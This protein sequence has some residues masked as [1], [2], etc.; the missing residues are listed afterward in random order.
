MYLNVQC[1]FS[2][3]PCIFV[4][5]FCVLCVL[6]RAHELLSSIYNPY[7]C[8]H[9]NQPHETHTHTHTNTHDYST[10]TCGTKKNKS[11]AGTHTFLC[12]CSLP[13]ASLSS[14]QTG[15]NFD[16]MFY[17]QS[18]TCCDCVW[19]SCAHVGVQLPLLCFT[20]LIMFH[21]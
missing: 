12:G 11:T 19:V 7:H 14:D 17:S 2:D 3:V 16:L 6:S 15:H 1:V 8:P 9:G 5:M 4:C 18:L 13:P 20:D 10:T 21:V